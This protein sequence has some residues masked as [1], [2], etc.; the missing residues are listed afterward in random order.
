VGI[1]TEHELAA[2]IYRVRTVRS[3]SQLVTTPVAAV[4]RGIV[5]CGLLNAVITTIKDV[6]TEMRAYA[7]LDKFADKNQI[8]HRV[9]AVLY[10]LFPIFSGDMALLD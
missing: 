3:S 9:S 4:M 7:F 1:Q 5:V 6:L 10:N 2:I 8:C